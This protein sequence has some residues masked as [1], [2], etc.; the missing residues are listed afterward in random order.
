LTDLRSD[1]DSGLRCDSSTVFRGGGCGDGVVE[2]A[3]SASDV[4]IASRREEIGE[5]MRE[6]EVMRRYIARYYEVSK[7]HR[8]ISINNPV[9][10]GD[11]ACS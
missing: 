7:A 10:Q 11:G 9:L 5:V 1:R 2:H 3:A 8:D 4:P 6:T